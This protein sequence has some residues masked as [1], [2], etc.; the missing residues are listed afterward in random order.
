M[1]KTKLVMILG[2][3]NGF[4]YPGNLQ[5]RYINTREYWKNSKLCENTPPC[6]RRFPI[7]THVGITV[8]KHGKCSIFFKYNLELLGGGNKIFVRS[9]YVRFALNFL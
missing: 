9:R 1:Q 4:Y 5:L 8:Y 6:G 2:I 3:I 7:S